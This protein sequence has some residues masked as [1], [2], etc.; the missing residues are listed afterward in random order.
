MAALEQIFKIHD[1]VC[2]PTVF[3]A[4]LALVLSGLADQ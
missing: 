4:H 3:A 1:D 2:E